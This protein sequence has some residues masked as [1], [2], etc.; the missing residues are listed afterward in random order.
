MRVE[1]AAWIVVYLQHLTLGVV[2]FA[3]SFAGQEISMSFIDLH[4]MEADQL[5]AAVA[6]LKLKNHICAAYILYAKPLILDHTSIPRN[7]NFISASV[8]IRA[9]EINVDKS[10]NT[11]LNDPTAVTK[12]GH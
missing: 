9:C 11:I 5:E 10:Q 8:G 12:A 2:G 3:P 6:S 1:C 7:R 4:S